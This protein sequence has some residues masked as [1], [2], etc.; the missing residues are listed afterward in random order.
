MGRSSPRANLDSSGVVAPATGEFGLALGGTPQAAIG[1]ASEAGAGP[2]AFTSPTLLREFL[3]LSVDGEVLGVVGIWRD[4]VPIV[5]RLEAMR[6][7]IVIV[8]LSAG[9]VAAGL[10]FLVFRSAQARLTRQTEALLES[11]HRDPLTDTL[12]HGALVGYL[13]QEIER[14]RDGGPA[15]RHRPR[16]T[17]TTSGSSTTTMVTP[18]ATRPSS[19]SRRRFASTSSRGMEFGR[20]GPD[21]FLLI[22]SI[23][24]P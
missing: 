9:I 6:R 2:G 19:R 21:E 4:G 13:A 3:P 12:N 7:E 24:A 20:Y 1:P 15:D 22:A 23:R 5:E 14:G 10:L 17:S 16:S 18:P 8:T 11:T